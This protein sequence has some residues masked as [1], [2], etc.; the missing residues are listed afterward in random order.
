MINENIRKCRKEKGISQEE[1]AVRL[2][3]VR[4]TVSKWEKGLSVP[5][6]DVLIKMA[7]LL[8]VPVSKLLGVEVENKTTNDITE[9][10]AR[11]NEELAQRKQKEILTEQANNKRN[12]ILFL[13]FLSMIAALIVRNEI[14]SILL[15]G[16][17]NNNALQYSNPINRYSVIH[18]GRL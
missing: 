3:V 9:E 8:D 16:V 2:H 7:E 14:I 13:S 5:D 6:A 18:T 15:V 10:L 11:L 4:Q 1:L 17:K 12:Q